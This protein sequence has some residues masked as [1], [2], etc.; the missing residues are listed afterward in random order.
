MDEKQYHAEDQINLIGLKNLFYSFLRAIFRFVEFTQLVIRKKILYIII[1]AI[2]G[3][4][5]GLI[6]YYYKEK[7]YSASMTLFLNKLTPKA[8]G[9]VLENLNN[10]I[11]Y[12]SAN[13]VAAKLQIPVD[14]ALKL[15]M[16]DGQNMMERPL[17]TDTSTKVYQLIRVNIL[18]SA[19]LPVDT[20]QA[21]LVNFFRNLPFLKKIAEVEKQYL[22]DR[23]RILE[24]DLKKL[25][26]LKT[27]VN[28]FLATSKVPTTV[29]SSAVN[30]AQIYEQTSLLLKELEDAYGQLYV[31]NDP[32]SVVDGFNLTRSPNGMAL[33]ELL[34][35]F[36]SIG[37]FAGFLFGLLVETKHHVLPQ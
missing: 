21:G 2:L 25:D 7:T 14:V 30:P 19:P 37:L 27:E 29:Y 15:R 12:G 8:Y 24:S 35:I 9:T 4:G 26:T 3:S 31:Q 18:A 34:L 1:G 17:I 36:G 11:A 22:A 6:Y 20:L 23:I 10:L 16:I 28:R 13:E 32:V 33:A 5:I